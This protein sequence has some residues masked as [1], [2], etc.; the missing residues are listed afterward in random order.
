MASYATVISGAAR[1]PRANS[2]PGPDAEASQPQLRLWQ[3]QKGS[4]RLS[5]AMSE[6]FLLTV[7]RADGPFTLLSGSSEA[8]S[9]MFRLAAGG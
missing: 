1:A 8:V 2:V 7:D 5:A 6:W 3:Y 4:S 9:G